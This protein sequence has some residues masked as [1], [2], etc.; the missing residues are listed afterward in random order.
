[1]NKV[2]IPPEYFLSYIPEKPTGVTFLVAIIDGKSD[3]VAIDLDRHPNPRRV[4]NEENFITLLF[5]EI[6]I[7]ENK[8][9]DEFY[10]HEDTPIK[11]FKEVTINTNRISEIIE[12]PDTDPF[13]VYVINL[14]LYEKLREHYERNI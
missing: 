5:D 2:F 8:S 10:E 9:S 3:Y 11:A 14:Y 4:L 7:F 1:M 12:Y 13:Y 6:S